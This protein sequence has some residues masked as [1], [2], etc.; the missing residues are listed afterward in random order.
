MM[1]TETKIKQL[2]DVITFRTD[3][4]IGSRH[5][6]P[7]LD[8]ATMVDVGCAWHM[9]GLATE[10]PRFLI[11]LADDVF[12]YDDAL[13]K[14]RCIRL[15]VRSDFEPDKNPATGGRYRTVKVF[16]TR[17][18]RSTSRDEI[19][20]ALKQKCSATPWYS[21]STFCSWKFKP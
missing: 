17:L 19:L 7:L 12:E 9:L 5:I 10:L 11:Y 2:S 14:A 6:L 1:K 20:T 8:A 13:S 3:M 15:L 21:T 4:S 16:R 18:A